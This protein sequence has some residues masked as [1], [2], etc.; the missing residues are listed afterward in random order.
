MKN[1]NILVI[2]NKEIQY[3][4][5]KTGKSPT[6][7]VKY[8]LKWK[9]ANGIAQTLNQICKA[10]KFKSVSILISD[11]L[12]YIMKMDVEYYVDK[13]GDIRNPI[14]EK[15]E[16]S[17]PEHISDVIW[18][19]KIIS[20]TD[21]HYQIEV[22][23]MQRKLYD[24]IHNTLDHCGV[25]IRHIKPFSV[26]LSRVVNAD[27]FTVVLYFS[28]VESVLVLVKNNFVYFAASLSDVDDK[29]YIRNMLN[30]LKNKYELQ[31]DTICLY[32]GISKI[33]KPTDIDM[34]RVKK[35][36][37]EVA[38]YIGLLKYDQSVEEDGFSLDL[39]QGNIKEEE[40][41]IDKILSI[42]NK[43]ETP[44]EAKK[45]DKDNNKG[46]SMM[47]LVIVLV[48]MLAIMGFFLYKYFK[49]NSVDSVNNNKNAP[50]QSINTSN[51][52]AENNANKL[53]ANN[54]NVQNVDMGTKTVTK[55]DNS[56][57]DIVEKKAEVKKLEIRVLNG[58]TNRENLDSALSTLTLLKI[59]PTKVNVGEAYTT[60]YTTT[61]IYYKPKADV[62][63]VNKIYD[64]LKTNYSKKVEF[65]NKKLAEDYPAD[66]EIIVGTP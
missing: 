56:S 8:S 12:I 14:S 31:D 32:S 65:G 61:Y 3:V 60:D 55:D 63:K 64:I 37:I 11:A 5:V 17:I 7:E 19:Y 35:L 48:I 23:A 13:D 1:K 40:S 36:L 51:I 9:Y 24:E 18:D 42:F 45:K 59:G 27:K 6:V 66:I 43:E 26:T 57:G 22:A 20:H 25:K 62:D 41:F 44:S 4:E 54:N 16:K 21:R 29:S 53:D 10:H 15:L 50:S 46:S 47:I 58:T 2:T 30:Y 38:P 52:K 39:E 49:D 28:T 34:F 33:I